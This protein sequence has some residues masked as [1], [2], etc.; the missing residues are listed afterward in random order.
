MPRT[1]PRAHHRRHLTLSLIVA[2]LLAVAPPPTAQANNTYT[3]HSCTTP[4]GT[5]TGME[6]WTSSA[7]LPIQGQDPGVAGSCTDDDKHIRLDFGAT[8]MPVGSGRWLDWKF[9]AA[10][11][12]QIASVT[13]LRS[14]ELGW[15]VV[16]GTYGRPYVYDAWHDD[17]VSGNQLEFFFPPFGGDTLGTDFDPMLVQDGVSWNSVSLR[18]RCWAMMGNH[19]CGPF[20]AKLQVPRVTF[21]LTDTEAPVSSVSGGNLAGDDPVRGTG[22]LAFHASDMGG[23]VYRSSVS[24]DGEEVSRQV[25]DS[26]DGG[27]ADVEPE[28]DDPYEFG[29][30]RPCP[31]DAAGQ[32]Q[33]DT[34]ELQDGPHTF[35]VAV[36]DTAGNEDVV[37]EA[38]VQ[39]HNAPISTTLPAIGGTAKVGTQLSAST[40]QWDGAPTSYGYRWLRCDA[41][42]AGCAGI[43]GADEAAYTPTSA[44][45][46]HRLVADV[47][48]ENGSGDATARTAVSQ[49]VADAEGHTALT[50]A[51]DT[52]GD[53]G[54]SPGGIDGVGGIGG[55]T[56]PI[57]DAGGHVGNGSGATGSAHIE[58]AFRK[59]G[60][61]TAT[62]VRSP[63]T[64]SWTLVGRLVGADGGA[65]AGARLAVAWKVTGRNWTAHGGVRTGADGG[66][67]YVLPAGPSRQV[68]LAYFAFSD[69][70]GFISSNVITEDVLAPLTIHADRTSLVGTNVVRLSGRAGGGLI[71]RG[72]V[73]V[74]L[75]GYQAGWG[76]RVFRTVRTSRT[77]SWTT[78]YRFRL[79]HGRFG[80]RVVVPRQGG[81]PFVTTHSAAVYVTVIPAD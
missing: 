42:G 25:V 73:L 51:G 35:R 40:G 43:A 12:T 54:S 9:A 23:G 71:P 67:S 29:T 13:V 28:N 41:D 66:F 24:V 59:P 32:V 81:Y 63:R 3:V 8:Q 68:K 75:Q 80:F 49:L 48:A 20:R 15:P 22:T 18:V 62:R 56:N 72:G 4:S 50:P 47:T 78:R 2:T 76:W 74:T 58:L 16:P 14:F 45:A 70:R 6:G 52:P 53:P 26:G 69:S 27:C 77:G 1:A 44:D 60:G 79:P 61:R 33:F 38:A 57:G 31:L 64:R 55:L 46:Y 10:P 5:W 11:N 7:S 37:Y 19:D 34:A 21:I 65:I 36:E 39:T 30:P 17:D